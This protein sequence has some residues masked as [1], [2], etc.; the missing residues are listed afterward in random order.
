MEKFK[1]FFSEDFDVFSTDRRPR[2]VTLSSRSHTKKALCARGAAYPLLLSVV[3]L[4]RDRHWF[5]QSPLSS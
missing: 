2:L 4:C 1:K 3:L 5:L